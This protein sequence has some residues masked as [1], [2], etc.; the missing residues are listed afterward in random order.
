M[1]AFVCGPTR[2]VLSDVGAGAWMTLIVSGVGLALALF[3]GG[4]LGT[5]IAREG[6]RAIF[7]DPTHY[8]PAEAATLAAKIAVGV[9]LFLRPTLLVLPW[10]RHATR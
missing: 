4:D 5:L 10:L 3:A 8:S 2:L 7:D 1:A 9:L 6:V